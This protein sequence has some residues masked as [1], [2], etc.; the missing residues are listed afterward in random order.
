MKPKVIFEKINKF[1]KPLARRKKREGVQINKTKNEKQKLQL[2]LQNYKGSQEQLYAN[3][4]GQPRRNGHILTKIHGT[5]TE[6]G[7]NGKYE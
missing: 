5:K 4:N 7:R 1:Y 2:T 3:Y 6:P